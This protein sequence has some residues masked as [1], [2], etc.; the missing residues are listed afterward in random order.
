MS[1]RASLAD[2]ER[3]CWH[4]SGWQVEQRDVDRLLAAVQAYA[5]GAEAP[6]VPAV[7]AVEEQAPADGAE[8]PAEGTTPPDAA[9]EV[10]EVTGGALTPVQRVHVTGALTLVCSGGCTPP[11]KVTKKSRPVADDPAVPEDWRQCRKCGG[12]QPIDHFVRD[13]H[14]PRGRKNV[15]RD[16]ENLRKRNARRARKQAAAT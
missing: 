1:E 15:C 11:K 6:A 3:L 12:A 8:R 5:Q 14:G 7:L 4:L 10:Y 16:C 13:T 2:V 9:E